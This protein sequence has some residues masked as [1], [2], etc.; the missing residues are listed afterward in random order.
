MSVMRPHLL[1]CLLVLAACAPEAV[2]TQGTEDVEADVEQG[3]ASDRADRSC[4]LVLRKAERA[5]GT[6]GYATVCDSGGACWF[7]WQATIDVAT[8][9]VVPGATTWVQWRNT[10]ASTW[11]RK[12]AAKVSGAPAG[13]Q[14]YQ[15]R[16]DR[17]T[18]SPGQSA[19]SLQRARLQLMPYQR[20]SDGSRVFDHNRVPGDFDAY[21]LVANNQWA[22]AEDASVCRPAGSA[23]AVLEFKSDWTLEQ[24]G[25]LMAA[26]TGTI[27][28]APSRLTKCRGSSGGA[29]RWDI[30]GFVRFQPGGQ[31]VQQSVRTFDAPN[32]V[33][34]LTRERP[35]P[36]TFTVP[37]GAR[38]AE[39]W[40]QN[41]GLSCQPAW[42]SL[43]GA[44][45]RFPIEQK[46]PPAIGW[47]GNLGSSLSRDCTAR[48]G[49]PEP[50]VLDGYIYERACSF[51]E[52][53]AWVP[54]ITDSARPGLLAARV[55][56][57]LDGVEQPARWLEYRGRVGNDS[58]YRFTLP[59]ELLYYGST[60]SRLDYTLALSTDGVTWTRDVTRSVK[61]DASWCNPSWGS[62]N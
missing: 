10:D 6:T 34:D 21:E 45:Y 11:S 33:P 14:R 47:F 26:G 51:V 2:V 53:D 4:Q 41:T 50:I 35:L 29:A 1:T 61:R 40:F 58:R 55:E 32:G 43:D 28:Y 3:V 37:A 7:V 15:V 57:K 44:N 20:L 36:F 52:L 19:T 24:H 60:W 9:A 22:I 54:G 42:D 48:A 17:K 13:Y 30:T 56:L 31:V 38:E 23:R 49:V 18:V 8:S 39:V 59:R 27:E 16:I 25:P 62:C 12:Q 46:A 5:T